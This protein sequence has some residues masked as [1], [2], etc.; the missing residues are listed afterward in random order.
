MS[1]SFD[2]TVTP[3]ELANPDDANVAVAAPVTSVPS[4]SVIEVTVSDTGPVNELSGETVIT[5]ACGALPAA[6]VIDELAGVTVN[7]PVWTV[8]VIDAVAVFPPESVPITL[9]RYIPTAADELTAIAAVLGEPTIAAVP[10][11]VTL[12]PVAV[13]PNSSVTF[14]VSV[15]FPDPVPADIADIDDVAHLEHP[16]GLLR[17]PHIPE[18]EIADPPPL[19]IFMFEDQNARLRGE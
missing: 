13:F 7:P 3:V 5:S 14:P 12:T 16:V 11:N 19:A 4:E 6:S 8:T 9:T 10:P 2:G 17:V 1:V 15:T 18:P